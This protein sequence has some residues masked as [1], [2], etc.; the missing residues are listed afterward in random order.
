MRQIKF[1]GKSIYTPHDWKYG[2][3]LVMGGKKYIIPCT[4]RMQ[5]LQHRVIPNTVCEFSGLIDKNGIEIY[6]NDIVTYKVAYPY[7]KDH[8]LHNKLH[9]SCVSFNN[10][11]FSIAFSDPST[12]EVIGSI[13][14]NPELLNDHQNVK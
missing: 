7:D 13:H 1:R 11:S 3:L 10:G 12:I 2:S 14:D 8:A 9:K 6:E 5:L 4:D